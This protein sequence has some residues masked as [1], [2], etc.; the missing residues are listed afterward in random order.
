MQNINEV[1]LEKMKIFLEERDKEIDRMFPGIREKHNCESPSSMKDD[2]I[3]DFYLF[4]RAYNAL[5]D[6]V[7]PIINKGKYVPRPPI[8]N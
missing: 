6:H 2:E 8:E 1:T 5:M 7:N 3:R 4:L